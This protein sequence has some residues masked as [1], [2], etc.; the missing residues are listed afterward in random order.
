MLVGPKSYP[1]T[2]NRQSVVLGEA[3]IDSKESEKEFETILS[4]T[5][6]T[7]IRNR[8]AVLQGCP[9]NSDWFVDSLKTLGLLELTFINVDAKKGVWKL[10]S[11]RI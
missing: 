5:D 1:C 11:S 3:Q 9:A 6:D 2:R 4:Q 7:L 10:L 8:N